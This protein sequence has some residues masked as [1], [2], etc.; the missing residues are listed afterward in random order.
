MKEAVLQY[1]KLEA[2]NIASDDDD[3][4]KNNQAF[5]DRIN[6]KIIQWRTYLASIVDDGLMMNNA[7]VDEIVA[8][9][10]RARKTYREGEDKDIRNCKQKQGEEDI[11]L[12]YS[13]TL[14][15]EMQSVN[16]IIFCSSTTSEP[17]EGNEST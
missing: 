6:F 12:D 3:N 17:K 13:S 7:K 14:R 10:E 1:I 11:E 4:S 9:V 16:A 15:H 8:M 2:N 5:L